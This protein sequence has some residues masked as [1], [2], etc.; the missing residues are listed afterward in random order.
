MSDDYPKIDFIRSGTPEW[1]ADIAE[2]K[3]KK[4]ECPGHVPAG[5]DDG[6]EM[7]FLTSYP[8][9][10]RCAHCGTAITEP[11][12]L[13]LGFVLDEGSGRRTADYHARCRRMKEYHDEHGEYPPLVM[14]KM[15]SFMW[16]GDKT[17]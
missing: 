11:D 7:E 14:G 16:L 8:Y 10:V 1:E 17:P 3:R 12:W 2:R 15:Q 5:Y 13:D 6:F 9:M 4:D